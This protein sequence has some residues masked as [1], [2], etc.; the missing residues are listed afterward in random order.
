[1]LKE[2]GPVE[3]E[4]N[5]SDNLG[6]YDGASISFPGDYSALLEQHR[7]V[8]PRKHGWYGPHTLYHRHPF[9]HKHGWFVPHTIYYRHP[10]HPFPHNDDNNRGLG[11]VLH[12]NTLRSRRWVQNTSRFHNAKGLTSIPCMLGGK[13]YRKVF[14]TTDKLRTGVLHSRQLTAAL[15][16]VRHASTISV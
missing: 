9:P 8:T 1:M 15:A 3:E 16:L 4:E 12:P 14:A 7:L 5:D 10:F 6:A 2:H 13:R 11:R